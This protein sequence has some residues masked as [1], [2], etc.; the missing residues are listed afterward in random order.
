M[1]GLLAIDFYPSEAFS[2]FST[3]LTLSTKRSPRSIDR[4]KAGGRPASTTRF[5]LV[6]EAFR[7]GFRK[8]VVARG[9]A[10]QQASHLRSLRYLASGPLL[11]HQ[12]V[13]PNLL[14]TS[15]FY[16]I[17]HA[18]MVV[19]RICRL[20][21]IDGNRSGSIPALVV[22][23]VHHGKRTAFARYGTSSTIGYQ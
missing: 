19:V 16:Q 14:H 3:T 10:A 21:R 2:L 8:C 4:Y 1:L 9:I 7:S 20:E 17:P 15:S 18:F 23:S 13:H 12:M 6:M 5:V 11:G 22:R